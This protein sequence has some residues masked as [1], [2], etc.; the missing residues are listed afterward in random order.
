MSGILAVIALISVF[1]WLLYGDPA[2]GAL[3]FFSTLSAALFL[4]LPHHWKKAQ[5]KR[6]NRLHGCSNGRVPKANYK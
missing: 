4:L 6:I 3:G 5:G 1:I 2:F